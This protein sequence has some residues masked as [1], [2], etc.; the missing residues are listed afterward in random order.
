[1]LLQQCRVDKGEYAR[2]DAHAMYP[3]MP[4]LN[5]IRGVGWRDGW[6]E[7]MEGKKDWTFAD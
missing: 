7:G 2:V 6:R 4:T 5:R 1:M 3:L